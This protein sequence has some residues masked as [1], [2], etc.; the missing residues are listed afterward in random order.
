MT[1]IWGNTAEEVFEKGEEAIQIFLKA[2]F[3]IKEIK[4]KGLAEEIEFLGVNWSQVIQ[5]DVLDS[6]TRSQVIQGDV[7]DSN[8]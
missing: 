2:G 3:A 4:V 8:T 5:G 6:N 1:I 7:L